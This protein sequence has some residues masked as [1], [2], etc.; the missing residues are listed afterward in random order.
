MCENLNYYFHK[1]THLDGES[2]PAIA[3][4]RRRVPGVVRGLRPS[5]RRAGPAAT[6][7]LV[8]SIGVIGRQGVDI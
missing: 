7:P 6:M 4:L 2:L 8:R 5:V 1:T 3:D